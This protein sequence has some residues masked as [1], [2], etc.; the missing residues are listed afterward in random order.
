MSDHLLMPPIVLP[1]PLPLHLPI[2]KFQIGSVVCWMSGS[3]PD[4]GRVVGIVYT[5]QA[6]IQA[7]GFH[8]AVLLDVASPSRGYGIL[9]DW[10]F[11]QDL[12]SSAGFGLS[13]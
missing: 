9:F 12:R 13:S 5:S 7:I 3:N 2:P 4:F 11:E 6:S 10:G 1:N 8:Y